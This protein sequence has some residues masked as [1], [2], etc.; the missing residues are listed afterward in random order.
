MFYLPNTVDIFPCYIVLCLHCVYILQ[1]THI[2]VCTESVKV[3]KCIPSTMKFVI[4]QLGH[5]IGKGFWNVQIA[6]SN[7]FI[8]SKN[9]LRV[10]SMK[11][12]RVR[13][14]GLELFLDPKNAKMGNISRLFFRI[15]EIFNLVD[16]SRKKGQNVWCQNA[17][18]QCCSKLYLEA[19]PI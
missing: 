14:F 17:H 3:T 5:F 13:H 11:C 12:V 1:V 18:F 6:T 9:V 16:L 19:P 2:S 10:D 8:K 4:L 7:L 15:F